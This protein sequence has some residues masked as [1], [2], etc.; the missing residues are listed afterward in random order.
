MIPPS[1]AKKKI[2]STMAAKRHEEIEWSFTSPVR[3]EK[4]DRYNLRRQG[5]KKKQTREETSNFDISDQ[6]LSG[7]SKLKE[8]F[9]LSNLN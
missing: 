9:E 1:K 5:K 6:I 3:M 8:K 4:K 7:N 2:E